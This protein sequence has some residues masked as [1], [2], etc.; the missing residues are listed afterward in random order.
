MK[1]RMDKKGQERS[2]TDLATENTVGI[3]LGVIMIFLFI[4]F[5]GSGLY[6]LLVTSSPDVDQSTMA[7]YNSLIAPPESIKNLKGGAVIEL[8]TSEE[9]MDFDEIILS[10]KKKNAIVAFDTDWPEARTSLEVFFNPASKNGAPKLA[11]KKEKELDFISY[12]IVA[13]AYQ[14]ETRIRG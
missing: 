7:G 5:F 1:L 12:L 2:S 6:F 14:G 4:A 10:V 3:P 8:L 9:K 11:P 13:T